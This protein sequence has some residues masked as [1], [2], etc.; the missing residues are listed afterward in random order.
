MRLSE[1]VGFS[2]CDTPTF[3]VEQRKFIVKTRENPHCVGFTA[4]NVRK[5]GVELG[6]VAFQA[7]SGRFKFTVRRQGRVYVYFQ[8]AKYVIGKSVIDFQTI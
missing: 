4:E 7:L 1:H 2:F 6:D 5:V 3:T 8:F